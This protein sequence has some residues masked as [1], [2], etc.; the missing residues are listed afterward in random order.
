MS[1]TERIVQAAGERFRYYGIAKTT[2]QEIAQDAGVAV[3]TLYLYFKNKDDLVVACAA[4]FVH[5]HRQEA[6]EV[7]SSNL[8]PD[9]KL[10]KYVL[11]RFRASEDIRAGS[12][13]AVELTR[14]VLRL[15]PDRLREEGAMMWEV[16]AGI[17][18]QGVESGMFG[19]GS[20]EEDAKVFLLSIA[21]FFP[22]AL[23][24]VLIPP[25][26]EDLSMV[27]DWFIEAWRR[28]PRTTRGAGRAKA[29]RARS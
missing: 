20:I 26:E 19:V 23:S 9:E 15:K 12:R 21:Y 1:K 5:R 22:N 3:G 24:E 16:V 10:R 11:G 29:R 25:T 13:H 27:V 17:L 8:A 2:M 4:D 6:A 18:R 28:G 7:L 14:A